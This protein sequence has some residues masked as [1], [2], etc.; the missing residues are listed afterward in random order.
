[1]V[2]KLEKTKK[3]E[4]TIVGIILI[5]VGSSWYQGTDEVKVGVQCAKICKQDW[6]HLFKF[7][8]DHAFPVNLWDIKDCEDGWFAS[9]DGVFCSK[10]K[11]RCKFIKTIYV[12]K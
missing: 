2:N 9:H 4:A 6:K 7:E 11:N 1:M 10:T 8:R 5:G 3:D 12:V